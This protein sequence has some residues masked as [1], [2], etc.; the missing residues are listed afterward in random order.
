MQA[1][2]Y[3][4]I[5]FSALKYPKFFIAASLDRT[6]AHFLKWGKFSRTNNLNNAS[7]QYLKLLVGKRVF[8]NVK[9]ELYLVKVLNRYQ[10]HT[11]CWIIL[12]SNNKHFTDCFLFFDLQF[13]IL[14]WI[15]VLTQNT[16]NVKEAFKIFVIT[17]LH[18]EAPYF[19]LLL[20]FYLCICRNNVQT[21]NV[22]KSLAKINEV[23][24]FYSTKL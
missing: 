15:L 10:E 13:S 19:K 24:P 9:I 4:I 11:F 23:G 22:Q 8:V 18:W 6:A 16:G 2:H 5:L 3:Y 17:S 21:R 20:L 14:E 7:K 1:Y 12:P